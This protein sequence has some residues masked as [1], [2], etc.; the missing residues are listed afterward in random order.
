MTHSMYREATISRLLQ[1]V[2]LFCKRALQKRRYS[3]KETYDFKELSNRSHPICVKWREECCVYSSDALI[4]RRLFHVYVYMYVCEVAE[5]LVNLL[6]LC[7][8]ATWRFHAY[9]CVCMCVWCSRN[10]LLSASICFYLLLSAS[11]CFYLLLSASICFYLLLQ[12]TS[13]TTHSCVRVHVCMCVG[14]QICC[15]YSHMH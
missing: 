12:C 6:S 15:I 2:G 1:I 9:V 4:V 13:A 10:M 11:I 14:G 3:A 5:Y 8:S 7:T